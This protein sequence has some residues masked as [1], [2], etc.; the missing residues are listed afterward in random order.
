MALPLTDPSITPTE[1]QGLE[2]FLDYFRQVVRRKAD[3]LTPEQLTHKVASSSLTIGGIVRHLTLVEESWFVE[4]LQGKDLSDPWASVDWRS[5][6][7]W[8]FDSAAGATAEELLEAHA[9][10]CEHSR[11]ILAEV[12]DLDALTARGDSGGAKFNVRWILIHL[13]EEYARH[14]GHADLIREDIDGQT[15]D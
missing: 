3:G 14:A 15:D 13:I 8:D 4:V 10:S 2:E 7:D 11:R 1:R 12:D 5:E 6:P 9:R